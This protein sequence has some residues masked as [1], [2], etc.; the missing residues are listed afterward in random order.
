MTTTT[1]N[2]GPSAVQRRA[3]ETPIVADLGTV[4]AVTATIAKN[5]NKDG[6]SN[7][8]KT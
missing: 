3:Y 2:A 8:I 7:N 5:K 4:A 6:G 1:P